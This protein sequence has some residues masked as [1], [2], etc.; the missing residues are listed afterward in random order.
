[1]PPQPPSANPCG[2]TSLAF[3]YHLPGW[4]FI[5]LEPTSPAAETAPA[6]GLLQ[7]GG[8]HESMMLTSNLIFVLVIFFRAHGGWGCFHRP[9]GWD[10]HGSPQIWGHCE[11]VFDTIGCKSGFSQSQN[12]QRESK[13]VLFTV[14]IHFLT[15]KYIYFIV[16][17]F[18]DISSNR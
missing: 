12:F 17:Y 16:K 1:M 11:T 15:F 13:F 14:T 6:W 4:T 3:S 7:G 8:W 18:K 9:E 10:G 5:N 2:F